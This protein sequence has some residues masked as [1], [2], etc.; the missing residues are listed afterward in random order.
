MKSDQTEVCAICGEQKKCTRDHVPPKGIFLKPRLKNLVTVPACHDCNNGSSQN[1]ERFRMYLALHVGMH[2]KKGEEL[3]KNALKTFK[4]NNKLKEQIFDSLKPIDL[5]TP[6]GVFL[7]T[8]ASVL[9]DSEAHDRIIERT[10]RG[11]FYH[12][13]GE[14]LGKRVDISVNWHTSLPEIWMEYTF[15]KSWMGEDEFI[16]LHS[17]TVGSPFSTIWIFQFYNSHWASGMTIAK[18]GQGNKK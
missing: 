4:S 9:W 10:I 3:F 7:G 12:H 11:L 8:G 14:V 13:Y 6:G 5:K 1:D 16:Y 17:Q 2:S 18:E 15:D